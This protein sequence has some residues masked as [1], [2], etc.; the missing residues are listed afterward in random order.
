MTSLRQSLRSLLWSPG[1]T[2]T[3]VLTLSLGMG[4]STA[5]FSFIDAVLLKPAGGVVEQDRLVLVGEEKPGSGNPT[6]TFNPSVT[7]PVFF[8]WRE[9][10]RVFAQVGASTLYATD[11]FYS[12]ADGSEVLRSL[13]AS[14]GFFETLGVPRRWACPCSGA[15][16]SRR[17]IPRDRRASQ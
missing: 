6:G 17:R 3:A 1:F 13:G 12:G 5:M 10:S 7:P 11:V 2:I 15:V 16:Q 4:L 8:G 14:A 9:H